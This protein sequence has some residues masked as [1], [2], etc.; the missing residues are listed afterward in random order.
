MKSELALLSPPRNFA[1][2]HLPECNYPGVVVQGDT[3]H[4]LIC[5]L[6]EMQELQ[7]AGEYNDLEDALADIRGRLADALQGY[8]AVCAERG[9]G[10]PCVKK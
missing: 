4:S 1:V 5:E 2:V 8:E 3:L 7:H 10:L 9:I 6:Q